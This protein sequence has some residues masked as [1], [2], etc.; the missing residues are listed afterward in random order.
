MLRSRTHDGGSG[1]DCIMR[2]FMIL[3][4]QI[5]EGEMG[6][7]CSTYGREETF[8]QHFGHKS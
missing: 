2:S 1:E 5:K 3:M 7:A 6:R 8:I 4:L